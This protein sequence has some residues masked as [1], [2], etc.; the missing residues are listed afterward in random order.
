M[1]TWGTG[2]SSTRKISEVPFKRDYVSSME[3]MFEQVIYGDLD[4]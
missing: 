3:G 2:K 1:T 4:S